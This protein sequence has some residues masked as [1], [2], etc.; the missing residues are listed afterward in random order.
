MRAATLLLATLTLA[1]AACSPSPPQVVHSA[2]GAASGSTGG[3]APTPSAAA[4]AGAPTP[5]VPSVTAAEH[6]FEAYRAPGDDALAWVALYYAVRGTPVDYAA[7]AARL[8]PAYRSTT[9]AFAQQDAQA[10]LKARLDPAIAQ[11]KADPYVRL[12]PVLM[13]RLTYDLAQHRYDLTP[14]I[15]S[16]HRL[17]VA[18]GN[19]RVALASNPGLQVYTP[20]S[21]AEARALE[22]AL[23][24]NP[25]QQLDITIYGKVVAAESMGGDPQVTV[26]PTRVVVANAFVDGSTKPLF[27]ATAK[28]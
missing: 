15:G 21:E 7:V 13:R 4:T 22:Q 1:L 25:M 17:T 28:P 26:V 18:N 23:S 6:P 14:L 24:A 27:I 11:A 16:Q 2:D 8:D 10:R 5:S 3:S 9:D 19:A 20:A 12:P